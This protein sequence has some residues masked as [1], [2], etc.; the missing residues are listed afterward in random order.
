MTTLTLYRNLY[1]FD[2]GFFNTGVETS[3]GG[4]EI[5]RLN[6]PELYKM[7]F[8]VPF[9]TMGNELWEKGKSGNGGLEGVGVVVLLR[10]F[11][12]GNVRGSGKVEVNRQLTICTYWTL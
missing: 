10:G 9:S 11:G 12:L 6:V 3:F 2:A 4:K 5:K 1:F 7:V 8:F